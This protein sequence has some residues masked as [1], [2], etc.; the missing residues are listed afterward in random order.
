MEADQLTSFSALEVD[1]PA[2]ASLQRHGGLKLKHLASRINHSTARVITLLNL[3]YTCILIKFNEIINTP[4]QKSLYSIYH[5]QIPTKTIIIF[6]NHSYWKIITALHVKVFDLNHKNMYLKY[7][8]Y[9]FIIIF[10]NSRCKNID[11]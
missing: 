5:L 6:A 10:K 2:T 9:S 7:L 8:T 11:E 3:N 1:P 4:M